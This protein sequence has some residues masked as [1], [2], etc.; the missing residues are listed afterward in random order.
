MKKASLSEVA[1]RIIGITEYQKQR[2]SQV[3][4]ELE[5]NIVKTK[6]I[7]NQNSKIVIKK[8]K[9]Q[10]TNSAK[11]QDTT[12]PLDVIKIQG[13]DSRLDNT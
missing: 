7:T 12:P 8:P 3:Q 6:K 10:K 1:N 13:G 11:Q 5:G 4:S 9:M 2:K